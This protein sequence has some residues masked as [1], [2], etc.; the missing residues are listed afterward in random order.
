M[1]R[2]QKEERR[3][4]ERE[5]C[6]PS[7]TLPGGMC[8]YAGVCKLTFLISYFLFIH[9]SDALYVWKTTCPLWSFLRSIYSL[10]KQSNLYSELI[11]SQVTVDLKHYILPCRF[12]GCGR[13]DVS[14]SSDVGLLPAINWH[15]SGLIKSTWF[16]WVGLWTFEILGMNKYLKQTNDSLRIAKICQNPFLKCFWHKN[17]TVRFRKNIVIW[18]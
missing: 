7:Y 13:W 3:E 8:L 4:R 11:W 16:D 14:P 5:R 10:A 17:Y 9:H 1:K 12:S 15:T 2:T 6:D 18:V